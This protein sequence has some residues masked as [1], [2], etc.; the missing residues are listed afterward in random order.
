MCKNKH[1]RTVRRKRGVTA[2]S[3][4]KICCKV[5]LSRKFIIDGIIIRPNKYRYLVYCKVNNSVLNSIFIG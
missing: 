2:L 1:V 4:M 5:M 3:D